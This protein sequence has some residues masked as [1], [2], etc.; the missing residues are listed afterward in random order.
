[1]KV[2]SIILNQDHFQYNSKTCK[3]N[4]DTRMESQ[5]SN[6]TAETFLQC[7]DS[8]VQFL[9]GAGNFSIHHRVQSGSGDHPASYP[10][11]TRGSFPGGKAA[12]A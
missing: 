7:L 3:L 9:A 4:G 10:L 12:V 2:T 1:V 8:R 5:V 11:G 6:V